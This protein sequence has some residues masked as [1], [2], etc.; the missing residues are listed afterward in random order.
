MSVL[1]IAEAG[2]NHNGSLELAKELIDA[3]H[4]A[5]ADIIKFQTFKAEK[6]VL[7]SATKAEYQIK[8]TGS[9]ESQYQ[10]LKRLELSESD[11]TQLQ[12]YCKSVGITF[13]ST[14]FDFDSIAF[15]E[16][17][18]LP[19][20]KLPSGEITNLPYLKKIAET[21]RDI[22]LS[23]GMSTMD[24]IRT[25]LEILQSNGAGKISLL[26]CNTEYPTPMKD[27]NLLAMKSI[28]REFGLVTG[29]SD[30]TKGIEVPIAAVAL[31]AQIIEKHF[32]L[33]TNMPGPD[34]KASLDPLEFA[35]M[36]KAI[37]NIESALGDGIKRPSESEAKN[38]SLVRKS[39]VASRPI[40]AG[41]TFTEE[42]LT[43]KRPGTGLS[44]LHWFEILGTI[45][46][47][48]Y[49]TDEMVEK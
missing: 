38:I 27:V 48:D 14:P 1:I 16:G 3:A 46:T 18:D 47:R 20:W 32:T 10:M 28:E 11:F 9:E 41:E 23:T 26:H 25:A 6:I 30:H 37:R 5:G 40:S 29:Y 35:E 15:L 39:I 17:L 34:H 42:N 49:E 33:D 36:V 21:G 31:G 12:E 44:P 19:F 43:V 2:V 45:A 13:L 8:E 24:E 7:Q 4:N 22:V